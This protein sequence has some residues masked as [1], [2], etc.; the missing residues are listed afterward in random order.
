MQFGNLDNLNMFGYDMRG[1]SAYLNSVYFT[2]TITQVKP[3]GE[4][5]RYANDRGPWEPDTHY[6]YYDRVSVLGYLWLCVNI[7]G[8]DT[9]PSDSNPDWLMQVSKG[10]T[11]EGLIV[12]RSEWWPGR[13]YCNE[14]EVS[15]TVQPLRYLD[16]ALIKDLGT[17]TGY[18]AYKCIST[19]D[20]GHGQ[21]KHLSSSDNKPGTPGGVEYW[22]ELA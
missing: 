6:D 5:I 1:Y 3:N 8:T 15:P 12:R 10:D 20:R 4:E 7:N 16:I 18:K 21:G 22:E 17:S 19:I 9:K 13:L 14:S 2:G 11:G